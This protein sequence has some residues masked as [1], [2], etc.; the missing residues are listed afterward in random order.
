MQHLMPGKG[1]II[2]CLVPSVSA[3][4]YNHA[5]DGIV[6][7][8]YEELYH[9][10]IMQ[11]HLDAAMTHNALHALIEQGVAG[12]LIITAHE[13]PL[14]GEALMELWSHDIHTVLLDNCSTEFPLDT[15]LTDEDA[16]AMT[17]I[18]YLTGL[19]HRHLA[20]VERYTHL[21]ATPHHRSR[22]QLFKQA[23]A[24]TGT[25]ESLLECELRDDAGHDNTRAIWE[26]ILHATPRPTAIWTT[27]DQLAWRLLR[28]AHEYGVRI[29]QDISL[30]GCGNLEAS[31]WI[32][33]ALSTIEQHPE[34]IGR[35]AVSLLLR[36]IQSGEHPGAVPPESIM[37]PV[38]ILERE[39]CAPL[40]S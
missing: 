34:Q 35:A 1:Q 7:T 3:L 29:P 6:A 36:R 5:L 33:P 31:E 14:R 24:T 13:Q 19:G 23:M 12:V 10:V 26:R 22:A 32:T 4:F 37:M 28:Y 15:V 30:L 16:V 39:S 25:V 21:H 17:A 18:R 8:A 20:M 27:V 38:T 40:P 9:V 11:T 2:G